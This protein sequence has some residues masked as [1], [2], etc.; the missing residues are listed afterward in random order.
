MRI[1]PININFMGRK[2]LNLGEV[3]A[4]KPLELEGVYTKDFDTPCDEFILAQTQKASMLAEM[5]AEKNP[6]LDRDDLFQEAMLEI[7]KHA[8][9]PEGPD[10]M[11]AINAMEDRV[12][13][14]MTDPNEDVVYLLDVNPIDER[15]LLDI[16]LVEDTPKVV[17]DVLKTLTPRQEYVLKERMNGR[18]RQDIG[19]ELGVSQEVI[20]N[21]ELKAHKRLRHPERASILKP[22]EEANRE[23]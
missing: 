2:N 9:S 14:A 6:H 4:L 21:I 3:E 23:I 18:S 15:D 12:N 16:V 8:K 17:N 13:K 1:N 20:R 7:V 10:R 11:I 5:V 22:Y 19:D